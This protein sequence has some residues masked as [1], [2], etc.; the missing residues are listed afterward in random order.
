MMLHC[1]LM[2]VLL[3]PS[4]SAVHAL[5]E[6]ALDEKTESFDASSHDSLNST[7][8]TWNPKEMN[9]LA[10]ITLFSLPA[11]FTSTKSI[12]D[13]ELVASDELKGLVNFDFAPELQV[14][15]VT[16]N[17]VH[18]PLITVE[19][20]P[21]TTG[22][23][24]NGTISVSE[25]GTLLPDPLKVNLLVPKLTKVQIPGPNQTMIYYVMVPSFSPISNGS[26]NIFSWY[27]LANGT[28]M[29]FGYPIYDAHS[30]ET[31]SRNITLQ[32]DK[33]VYREGETI[34]ITGQIGNYNA[35]DGSNAGRHS[36]AIYRVDPFVTVNET[37]VPINDN[38][39][40]TLRVPVTG[41][42]TDGTYDVS[43]LETDV[44]F[45]V[46]SSNLN[47]TNQRPILSE[48]PHVLQ[49]KC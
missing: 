33:L 29:P 7:T 19:L 10:T 15:N 22:G 17:K 16:A 49:P 45:D 32:T 28:Q 35:S 41:N 40:F 9:Y 4:I 44:C 21:N 46:R 11:N 12:Q 26:A 48:K 20:G 31:V 42:L 37:Y 23:W 43:F 5:S 30:D 27:V 47:E 14:K 6:P 18:R 3:S 34:T 2:I 24:H 1:L 36:I 13:V 38:G 39:T 8:I 25:N